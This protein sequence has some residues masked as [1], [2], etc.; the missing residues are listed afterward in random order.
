MNNG[1][2][3]APLA[4]WIATVLVLFFL[5]FPIF[6]VVPI[7]FSAANYLQF[8]PRSLSLRWYAAY[9][10][11]RGWVD[12]TI[13]SAE[14]AAV[15]T[16]F[17]LDLGTLLGGAVISEGVFSMQGLGALLIDAVSSVDLPLIVGVTLF[18]AFL[19][20]FANFLQVADAHYHAGASL[21]P[22]G[23]NSGFNGADSYLTSPV[24]NFPTAFAGP[25]IK[26]PF[27]NTQVFNFWMGFSR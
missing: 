14:V 16:V 24:F 7:S 19:V 21:V 27:D 20:I 3:K 6:V 25:P 23:F 17:G 13:L 5:V 11:G 9:F 18:A 4:V 15:V 12:A 2:R 26:T 22:E 10:G 1:A 8:P